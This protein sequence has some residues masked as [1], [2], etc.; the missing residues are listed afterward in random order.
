MLI[1]AD[2]E[3]DEKY[4]LTLYTAWVDQHAEL[5]SNLDLEAYRDY[6]LTEYKGRDG[7]HLSPASVRAHLSTIRG[8]YKTLLRSNDLRDLLYQLTN[9]YPNA[10]DKKAF[11]DETLVRLQ[12]AVHPDQAPVDV[13]TRQDRPDDEHL[14]LTTGQANTLL[15]KPGVDTLLGL[16]NTAIITL[17][18]CTGIRE[19]ELCALD[20]HDLRKRLGNELSLHIRQGKGC[21]RSGEESGHEINQ[22]DERMP[23][24]PSPRPTS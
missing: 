2:V 17:L 12:N 20:V 4:R 19:A 22:K 21:K 15:D 8:Q 10:A 23:E 18:L 16:R 14:R 1:S 9:G 24:L 11:V 5:W 13:V 6:L 3:K 7:R